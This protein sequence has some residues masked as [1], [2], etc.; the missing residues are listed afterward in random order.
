[1]Q[2]AYLILHRIYVTNS[3]RIENI[4]ERKYDVVLKV[5][6]ELLEIIYI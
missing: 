4:E 6:L 5:N 1:M 3:D 2:M